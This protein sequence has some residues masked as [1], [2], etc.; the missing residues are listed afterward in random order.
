MVMTC[1]L[2]A[3]AEAGAGE[4]PTPTPPP[5]LEEPTPTET[6]SPEEPTPTPEDPTPTPA[7]EDCN[8]WIRI[9]GSR[10]YLGS[11]GNTVYGWK[12][13][14]SSNSKKAAVKWC[15]FNDEG[16]FLLSVK[17]KTKNTWVK[18]DGKKF[19]FTKKCKPIE[20]GIPY[21]C[22]KYKTFVLVDISEQKLWF[23]KD[24]ILLLETDVITGTMSDPNSQTPTG[25]FAV[26]NKYK[27]K[28]ED[29]VTLSGSYGVR[30]VDRWIG[31]VGAMIGFH[32][33]HLFRDEAD[34]DN[35]EAY[36]IDGSHGCVNMKFND[37]KFLYK[38]IKIG[39]K[40][41]IRK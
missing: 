5:S 21:Y 33:V 22:Y 28:G 39:D 35:K 17:A 16:I 4:E 15:Y 3:F 31:F 38:N 26:T 32:D 2:T 12:K 34:F 30:Y 37:V 13:I 18:V 8:K 14:K 6:P 41:I 1:S 29:K 36:L 40:V 10:Y 11:D 19:Y 7:P 25:T 24:K 20:S 9:D 23:Y 27:S